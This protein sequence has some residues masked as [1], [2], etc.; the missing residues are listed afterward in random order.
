MDVNG[1]RFHLVLGGEDWGF[2]PGGPVVRDSLGWDAA[3]ATLGLEPLPVTFPPR[4]AESPPKPED[5]RGA[6]RDRFGNWYWIGEDERTLYASSHHDQAPL[7]FW[8][9]PAAAAGPDAAPLP[10]NVGSGGAIASGSAANAITSDFEPVAPPPPPPPPRLVGLAVTGEHYLV[11]GAP[12]ENALL[13]FDLAA[14]GPPVALRWPA[15]VPFRPWDIAAVDDGGVWVLDREHA[16][17]WRLDKYLRVQAANPHPETPREPDFEPVPGGTT[18][19]DGPADDGTQ[20]VTWDASVDVSYVD[21]PFAVDA[22]CDG[23]ALVLGRAQNAPALHRF[24][25]DGASQMYPLHLFIPPIKEVKDE[26]PFAYDMAFVPAAG[27]SFDAVAGTVFLVTPDGNQ[28]FG[29][30]LSGAADEL[31]ID[32]DRAFYPMRRF[33]GRALVTAGGEA[34]YDSGT[35]WVSLLEYPRPRFTREATFHLPAENRG[36]K[37][38]EL[39]AWDGREPGCVWHRLLLDGCIPPESSITVESRAGDSADELRE[40]IWK[41]EPAPYLR[42]H[43]PELPYRVTFP[44]GPEGETG[45]WEL[46]FQEARG[47]YLQLRITLRGN[48]RITPRLRALRAYYPRFS[49]LREY[50]PAVYREDEASASFLDRYLSNVEGQLTDIEGR[51]ADAQVLFDTSTVPPEFLDWLS[52]WLGATLDVGWDEAKKR[53]FLANATR[54]FASRG[55]REGLVRALRLALEACVDPNLFDDDACGCGGSSSADSDRAMAL[56]ATAATGAT[57]SHS[58]SSGSGGSTG[59][60][61][62][63]CGG[64]GGCGGGAPTQS[65]E[66][67]LFTVR[68]VERFL[69]RGA[70]GVAYGD[71]GDLAGPGTT[72]TAL[73][74]TPAQGTEPLHA[75]WR[76]WLKT[77]YA[78]VDALKRAWDVPEA[79]EYVSLD[80][81]RIRMPATAP[82]NRAVAEDWRLF[83]S[84]GLGFTY[85]PPAASERALW[86]DFLARRHRQPADLNRAWGLAGTAALTSFAQARF[87]AELP[88]P[89]AALSDWITFVSVV[90]PMQRAAHRFTVLVPVAPGDDQERQRQRRELARRIAELEKPAHTVVETRLYWAAFRVGEARLGTDTL[91]GQG[92]RFTALVLDRGELA[93]SYLGW[94]EPWNVRGRLVVGRD[95]VAVRP[96]TRGITSRWT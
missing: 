45:T 85:V 32:F 91:L 38:E 35:R 66:A 63:G 24:T 96:R 22:L 36:T 75:R 52:G 47:R 15:H 62:C 31:V 93:G 82:A 39:R 46:L 21:T 48:G 10:G 3:G 70:P 94:T 71:V 83:L 27:C 67:G 30:R 49:Y 53:F 34:H 61:G 14:G 7:A 89:T 43:G 20:P 8:P 25:L 5:R 77:R 84:E 74:W 81:V 9:N 1:T 18:G 11:A 78:D 6:G 95:P 51:I 44:P 68:V 65:P 4:R 57:H 56:A 40:A 69:T 73:A 12:D 90:V 54:M 86:A 50:L 87:P 64:A 55:T 2:A 17:L 26:L 29:F 19:D 37:I 72:T 60:C 13:V 76:S 59:D 41:T 16:R 42:G 88:E 23:S 58:Y 28:S 79:D 92:A 80:D 33:G